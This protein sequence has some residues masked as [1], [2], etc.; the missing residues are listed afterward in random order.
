MIKSIEDELERKC[1][2]VMRGDSREM[3]V[4]KVGANNA[5]GASQGM[6]AGQG[7]AKEVAE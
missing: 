6:P 3:D 5:R 7:A 2:E 1:A 4:I